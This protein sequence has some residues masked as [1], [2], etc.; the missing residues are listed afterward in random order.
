MSLRFDLGSVLFLFTASHA[1]AQGTNFRVLAH[2]D[3]YAGA[4]AP[5]NNARGWAPGASRS[6][7]PPCLR[8]RHM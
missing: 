7:C 3:R 1:V 4:V 6:P 5:N 8:S 2:V